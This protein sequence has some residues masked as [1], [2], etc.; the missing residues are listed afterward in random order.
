MEYNIYSMIK[1]F[2]D[3]NNSINES[4]LYY[5]PTFRERLNILREGGSEIAKKLLEL[6]LED[7]P[8]DITFI[9]S[10]EDVGYLTF[11]PMDKAIEKIL[12]TYGGETGTKQDIQTNPNRKYNDTVYNNEVSGLSNISIY[13]NNRNAIKVGKFVKKILPNTT[14]VQI[15]EF[16]NGIKAT[17]DGLKEKIELVSGDEISKWYKSENCYTGGTLGNSCM[18]DRNYFDIYTKNP[19]SVNLLIMKSGTKI[20]ARAL[21]WKIY[22]CNPKLGFT[23]YMDRVYTHRDYQEKIMIDFANKKGWAY[24]KSGGVYERGI[25]YQGESND[26]KMSVKVKKIEYESY[27]YMDTFSRYDYITGL[28]W[29]DIDKTNKSRGHIL[30]STRGT[31]DKGSYRGAI[32]RFGD[33]L[34][35][36][37]PPFYQRNR[38]D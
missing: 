27:P 29:N 13:T 10:S 28:L 9:N 36:N 15:E 35:V 1:N 37:I 25:V 31:F 3:F 33:F 24:R 8:T 20:V 14:D 2:K 17:Q 32:R 30:N 21:V 5:S 34:G 16:V 22:S 11:H 4:V 23:Y 38:R 26:V 6:E 7:L 12:K 19:K 18:V